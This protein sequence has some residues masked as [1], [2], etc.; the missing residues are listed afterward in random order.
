MTKL[1][2]DDLGRYATVQGH[3]LWRTGDYVWCSRCGSY[4]SQQVKG[5]GGACVGAIPDKAHGTAWSELER[6]GRIQLMRGASYFFDFF[7]GSWVFYLDRASPRP[8]HASV[9]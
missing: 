5:L 6:W 1:I 2:L 3:R 4:T 9:L 7:E 8:C